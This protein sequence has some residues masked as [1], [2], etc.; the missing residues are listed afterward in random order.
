MENEIWKDIQGYEGRYQVSNMGR[1]RRLALPMQTPTGYSYHL[2]V[3]I[4]KPSLDSTTG[5]LRLVLT[6]GHN[7]KTFNVHKLVALHFVPGYK[8]GLIVNHKNE[9]RQDNRADNLE[10]CTYRY[11]LDYSN[12]ANRH[13]KAVYQYDLE[14]NYIKTFKGRID[15]TKEF[16]VKDSSLNHALN[17]SK[18]GLWN[19]Y[20]WSYTKRSKEEWQ[21]VIYKN[22]TST[23]PV[24]QYTINGIFL[25]RFDSIKEAALSVGNSSSSI[26]NCCK[27]KTKSSAGYLWRYAD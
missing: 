22:R 11:N 16:G 23:V 15:I 6:D 13:K 9:I 3:R 25:K 27:R 10:W 20:R 17:K 18:N 19:G 14:G 24:S 21:K 7:H 8:P 2:N 26:L 1:V 12:V 4:R 5:Y